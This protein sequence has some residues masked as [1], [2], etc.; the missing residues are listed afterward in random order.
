MDHTVRIVHTA[1]TNEYKNAE[2]TVTQNDTMSQNVTQN[3]LTNIITVTEN[4]IKNDIVQKYANNIKDHDKFAEENV[5]IL[6]KRFAPTKNIAPNEATKNVT[7]KLLTEDGTMLVNT[8]IK[9]IINSIKTKKI[10]VN[11]LVRDYF[12]RWRYI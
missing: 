7:L 12:C 8:T 11:I 10:F 9:N 5:T 6:P 4:N 3:A 1:T 2:D